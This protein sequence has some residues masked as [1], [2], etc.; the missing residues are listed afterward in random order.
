MISW[1]FTWAF[2]N[3]TSCFPAGVKVHTLSVLTD[4]TTQAFRLWLN[5]PLQNEVKW[6]VCWGWCG[7]VRVCGEESVKVKVGVWWGGWWGVLGL[8]NQGLAGD[9]FFV[10]VCSRVRADV[11]MVSVWYHWKWL[12]SSAFSSQFN[13]SVSCLVRHHFLSWSCNV[14][15]NLKLVDWSRFQTNSSTGWFQYQTTC[16]PLYSI[17]ACIDN[18]LW[19]LTVC[20]C[21]PWV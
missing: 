16:S 8:C 6:Q 15:I 12:W 11:P 1:V 3:L 10:P 20:A 13:V 14:P 7:D 9:S 5:H 4:A 19:T 2:C 21:Y 18:Y 17:C